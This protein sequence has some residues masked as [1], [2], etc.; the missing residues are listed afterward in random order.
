LAVL[1]CAAAVTVACARTDAGITT[2]VKSR[3]AADDMVKSYQID[4]D[5]SRRVVTLSGDVQTT[6]AKDQALKLARETDGVR[7]VIDKLTVTETAPT[8]GVLDRDDRTDAPGVDTDT[9]RK[10]KSAGESTGRKAA[11][12]AGKAGA[13][14]TDAALTSAVKSK[15]LADSN[16]RGLKIDVDTSN[17]V[18]TL[19]GDVGTQAEADAA[20]RLA[21]TTEGVRDVVSRLRI[22]K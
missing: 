8:T 5:T 10:A 6:V 22:R 13:V 11:E 20:V 4:V 2:A 12:A 18:V 9:G 19:T 21:R 3:L 1:V 16:V 15:L 14:V 17:A 7:D